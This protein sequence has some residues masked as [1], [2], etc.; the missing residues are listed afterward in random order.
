VKLCP[1]RLLITPTVN[2][3]E[4]E[5]KRKTR[6][7]R[8]IKRG[9]RWPYASSLSIHSQLIVLA[10]LAFKAAGLLFISHLH[11]YA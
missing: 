5:K 8:R 10:I 11:I 2:E 6:R 7:R 1:E 9:P 3:D 4:N